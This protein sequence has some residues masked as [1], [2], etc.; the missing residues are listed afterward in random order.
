M[1][2][3]RGFYEQMGLNENVT[4]A[5]T[6]DADIALWEDL[7]KDKTSL[8]LKSNDEIE[9]YV[10]GICRDYFRTTKKAKLNLNSTL[11]EHGL[12]SLD[13]IEL[14]IQVEDDLGY[15][16]D[17]ENLELFQKPKH[18]VNFITQIEAYRDEFGRLPLDGV[19][20]GLNLKKAFAWK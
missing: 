18:F 14:V 19:H 9:R 17:A 5:K 20:E 11:K 3:T 16:I 13:L 2:A 15:V 8:V 4:V 10:M 7:A 12:D 1:V 6:G